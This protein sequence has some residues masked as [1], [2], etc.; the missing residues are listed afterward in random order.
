MM[1]A[2]QKGYILDDYV[3]VEREIAEEYGVPILDLNKEFV[4]TAYKSEILKNKYMP[5][6][7]HPNTNGM[8][9]LGEI[10]TNFI[11]RQFL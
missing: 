8:K 10:V 2:N 1:T 5:D 6:G 3:R 4:F 11:K 7:L 9:L